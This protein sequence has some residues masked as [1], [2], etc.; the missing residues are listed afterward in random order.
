LPRATKVLTSGATAA[1]TGSMSVLTARP[2]LTGLEQRGIDVNPVLRE[3][4][5][6]SEALTS[7]ETR[8]PFQSVR[9]LW[10][11]AAVAAGDRSFGVH[12]AE[13]LPTG[14]YDVFDYV[15]SAASTAKEGFSR[16]TR[17]IRLIHD[18]SNLRLAVEP[19]HARIVRRV[20]LPSPQYD[21]FSLS[22]L[23]IRSR[24]ATGSEWKPEFVTFQHE[25]PDHDGQLTRLFGCPV[26]FGRR[27]AEIRLEPS[28]LE[29]RHKRADSR[30][31]D[32]LCRYADSLVA[33]LPAEG[34]LLARVS[35]TIAQQMARELPSLAA[36]ALAVRVPDRTLQRQL[37]A[38]GTSYSAIADDVRRNLALKYL[39]DAG[40]SVAEIAYLLHF[41]D[42]TAFHRAFKRWTGESP[43]RYRRRLFDPA[44]CDSPLPRGDG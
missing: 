44:P 36:V 23:L 33:T 26:L 37:A 41:T 18:H 1:A 8:L 28:V 40:I 12:V 24:Q 2:A 11:V 30:L 9:R 22:L 20:S 34:S 32:V 21:E 35:S 5:L 15:M 39:G 17:Y 3:A 27:E 7:N 19:G 29:L 31:M 14:A 25:G 42:P 43:S 6:S 13:T 38:E 4:R 10:E 16:L